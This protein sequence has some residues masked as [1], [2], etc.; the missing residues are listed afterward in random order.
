VSVDGGGGG[1]VTGVCGHGVVAT[2]GVNVVK[3]P[4]YSGLREKLGVDNGCGTRI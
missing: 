2:D 4:R 1:A 3:P